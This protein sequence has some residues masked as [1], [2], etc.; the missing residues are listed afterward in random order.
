LSSAER[1]SGQF[2]RDDSLKIGLERAVLL[3]PIVGQPLAGLI[4]LQLGHK[5][6]GSLLLGADAW[7]LNSLGDAL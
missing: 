3:L 1:A 7:S 6:A 2:I 4:Q 5:M